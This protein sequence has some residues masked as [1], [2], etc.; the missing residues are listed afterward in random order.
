MHDKPFQSFLTLCN[1]MDCSPPGSSVLGISRQEYWRGFTFPSPED[2]PN[3]GIEPSSPALG[4]FLLQCMK[5]KSESPQGP[6][7]VFSAK[8]HWRLVGPV[9]LSRG[10]GGFGFTLRPET[11][12]RA[13]LLHHEF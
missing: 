7:S 2:L 1:P 8:N 5:V 12:H 13:G 6:L 11:D 4:H 10:E 3:P 9:H